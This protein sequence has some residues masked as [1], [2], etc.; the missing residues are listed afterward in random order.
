MLQP[1]GQVAPSCASPRTRPHQHGAQPR[2]LGQGHQQRQGVE[3][4][5]GGQE[6]HNTTGTRR[7]GCEHWRRQRAGLPEPDAPVH[8]T[9]AAPRQLLLCSRCARPTGDA[10]T[11]HPG[12]RMLQ[13]LFCPAASPLKTP[14]ALPDAGVAPRPRLS[15][16]GRCARGPVLGASQGHSGQ[17]VSTSPSSVR[18]AP[19]PE[20]QLVAAPQLRRLWTQDGQVPRVSPTRLSFTGRLLVWR[21]HINTV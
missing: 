5:E 9:L 20:G 11:R 14:Q 12:L 8:L 6:T 1:G 3:G 7:G 10:T 17:R 4:C 2:A 13:P 19:P 16:Q 18:A 21:P 15:T